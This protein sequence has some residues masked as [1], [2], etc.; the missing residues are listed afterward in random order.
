MVVG[1]VLSIVSCPDRPAAR[2]P[3]GIE[4]AA[5]TMIGMTTVFEPSATSRS[6][7]ICFRPTVDTNSSFFFRPVT[8]TNPMTKL[9]STLLDGGL[10]SNFPIDSLDRTDGKQPRFPTFGVTVMPNLPQGDVLYGHGCTA[11]QTFLSTWN[12][13][14]YLAEFRPAGP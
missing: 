2:T 1:H 9:T 14:D 13:P 8:L 10:L 3:P 4:S 11:M 7:T 6:K 5:L 12:W